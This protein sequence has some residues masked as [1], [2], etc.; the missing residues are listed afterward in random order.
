MSPLTI[1]TVSEEHTLKTAGLIILGVLLVSYACFQARNLIEGPTIVLD[2]I[3]Y[4]PSSVETIAIKGT[5]ENVVVL[6]L[7]GREIHT[8]E[9][10][11]FKEELTLT[12]GLSI[13]SIE[14]EDRFGRKTEILRQFVREG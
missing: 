12:H 6:R 5:A 2:N 4:T 7:N 10:G 3:P 1:G 11:N 9:S 13:V 14:A 8:D